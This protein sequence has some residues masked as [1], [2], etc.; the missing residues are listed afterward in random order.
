MIRYTNL[1]DNKDKVFGGAYSVHDE[2]TVYVRDTLVQKFVIDSPNNYESIKLEYFDQFKFFLGNCHKLVGL[3][4]YKYMC[5]SQ[6]TTESFGHFY[7]RYHNNHRLRLARGE[8]FYHQMVKARFY[9]DRFEWLEDDE[10]RSGDVLVISAP[11]SDTCDIYPNLENILCECDNKNIP[12][13]LDLAYLNLAVNLEINLSHPCIEYVVSSL[14]KV[15]PVENYR[16]GIRLQKQMFEDPLYVLNE[17]NCNYINMCSVYTGLGLM[18]EFSPAFIYD[19][20]ADKQQVY[21]KKL[22]LDPS[23]CVYFGID[24]NNKYTEYNRGG[25]TNR[26]C[27]SRIWDGRMK[28]E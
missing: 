25:T 7:L 15:F 4:D 6:G 14:S 22:D 13:L 24:K 12:V 23:R 8:Y 16:I 20:Y 19:K 26:L 11:F 3:E 10:L 9:K 27:F 17:P 5:F 1:P 18:K 2:D 21:C 28:Y